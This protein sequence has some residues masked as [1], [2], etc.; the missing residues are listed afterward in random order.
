MA[1]LEQ[2]RELV[3]RVQAVE[4]REAEGLAREQALQN[5]VQQLTTQLSTQPATTSGSGPHAPGVGAIDTRAL[6]KPE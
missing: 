4:A 6:G 2:I 1:T 5:Q 3:E